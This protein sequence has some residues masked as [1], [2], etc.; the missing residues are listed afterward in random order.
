MTKTTR[1]LA[2]FAQEKRADAWMIVPWGDTARLEIPS[3][4]FWPKTARESAMRGEA[5]E[6]MRLICGADTFDAFAD[7]TGDDPEV[8]A[9]LI[10]ELIVEELGIPL[11]SASVS[12]PS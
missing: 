4:A 5:A 8:I 11:G 1:D 7:Q 3:S 12:S 10:W 2:Q 9:N 6:A